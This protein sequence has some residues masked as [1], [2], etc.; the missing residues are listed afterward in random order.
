[1]VAL[2]EVHEMGQGELLSPIKTEIFYSVSG[3]RD[4]IVWERGARGKEA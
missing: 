2:K 1:M 4:L 3:M